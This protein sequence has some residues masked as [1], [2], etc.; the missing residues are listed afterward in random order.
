MRNQFD[1]WVKF[2]TYDMDK[3]TAEQS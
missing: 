3:T 2:M 1:A